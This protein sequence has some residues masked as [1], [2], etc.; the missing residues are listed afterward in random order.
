MTVA[1]PRQAPVVTRPAAARRSRIRYRTLA[2]I[3]AGAV[4]L[5][6]AAV[7]VSRWFLLETRAGADFLGS[8]P[9]TVPLPG[10]VPTGIPSWLGWQH[11]LNAFFIVLVIRTG[12]IVRT[13]RRPSASW[14]RK[15]PKPGSKKITIE[16]WTHLSLDLLWIVN[17]VVFVV[18]IFCTGQWGRIV[19][20]SWGVIPNAASAG[21][22]YLSLDW[23]S[24]DG[25]VNYNSLQLLAYFATVFIAAPLA[26][27]TGLRMSPL[28][29]ARN[30]RLSKAYPVELARAVHF[31]V[32]L[33]FVLFV[34]VHVGLV[35]STGA[36]R[37]LNHMYGGQDAV[38]WWGFAVFVVSLAATA[39]GWLLIRP[40]VMQQAGAVFGK[41]GR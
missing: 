17:G 20:T 40:A 2:W 29:P 25:W 38:N 3:V 23:P 27:V 8:Y 26:A 13:N 33:Y 21:L 30:E 36:L 9:G 31:P 28:W 18:V 14:T 6:C 5:V 12:W 4:V 7:L 34:I 24:E 41:I 32:M 10:W 35:F 39:G 1:A 19:P 15:H 11:F 16:L 22:Q 37:N